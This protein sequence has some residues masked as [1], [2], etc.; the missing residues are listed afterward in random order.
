M[1][2]F[3]VAITSIKILLL[4]KAML[5]KTAMLWGNN[6]QQ[7]WLCKNRTA[8]KQCRKQK[9]NFK[10]TFFPL[11]NT[12]FKLEVLVL[13]ILK[14]THYHW[15]RNWILQVLPSSSDYKFFPANIFTGF[16]KQSFY[17]QW[18]NLWYEFGCLQFYTFFSSFTIPDN[19]SFMKYRTVFYWQCRI[20]VSFFPVRYRLM[21]IFLF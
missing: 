8:S 18:K 6:S 20:Q 1:E 21:K 4:Y 17:C 9:E 7:F 15:S 3:F 12:G 2:T 11:V 10:S 5:V 14:Q 16:A 19:Y 13:L